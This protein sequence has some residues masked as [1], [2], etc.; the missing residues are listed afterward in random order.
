MTGHFVLFLALLC[1][2]GFFS[3]SETILFS[4]SRVQIHKFRSSPSHA[5]QLVVDVLR[6]PRRWLATILL[7]N[8]FINVSGA[9][10]EPNGEFYKEK[11][12]INPLRV[13]DLKML[14]KTGYLCNNSKI[15]EPKPPLREKWSI[16]GDPTEGA[17]VVLGKKVEF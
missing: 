17:L 16:L 13:K 14:I 11:R 10:F 9:G 1:C 12:K 3:S 6:E 8:E 4:L 5:A 2:S 7:G 15:L